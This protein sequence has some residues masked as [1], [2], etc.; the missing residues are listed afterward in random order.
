MALVYRREPNGVWRKLTASIDH[1]DSE[2]LL[3]AVS[4]WRDP[5]IGDRYF[6]NSG[7]RSYASQV[8]LYAKYFAG[9][10]LAAKPGTSNH[11]DSPR[12]PFTTPWDINPW[13]TGPRTQ[14][15]PMERWSR[16]HP[17]PRRE[18]VLPCRWERDHPVL[19]FGSRAR[20]QWRQASSR[21]SLSR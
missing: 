6:V 1:T 12:H 15:V 11:E 7:S 18:R 10:T 17:L 3:R 16:C 21:R 2:F 8:V 4:L 13:P 9:G 14:T 20:A 19:R 5:R